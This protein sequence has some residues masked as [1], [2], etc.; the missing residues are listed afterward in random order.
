MLNHDEFT[1]LKEFL[2]SEARRI[3]TTDF[4]A[5]DPVQ[6]PRRFDRL[7]DIELVSILCATIAWGNRKMICNNCQKMLTIMENQPY[8][9][10]RD[11]AYDE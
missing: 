6:F 9:E 11:Q 1:N 2:D 10:E 4:I 3:N 5:N 8:N 7:Q